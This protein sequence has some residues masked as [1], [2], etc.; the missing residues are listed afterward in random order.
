MDEYIEKAKYNRLGD[1]YDKVRRSMREMSLVVAAIIHKL[2]SVTL[3]E[4]E[5]D[6]AK[7]DWQIQTKQGAAETTFTVEIPDGDTTKT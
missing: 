4:A 7:M 3:T 5:M 2:G 1:E 6:A